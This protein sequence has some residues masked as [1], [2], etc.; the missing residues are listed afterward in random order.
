MSLYIYAQMQMNGLSSL[1]NEMYQ[2]WGIRD[3][4]DGEEES[5]LAAT[6]FASQPAEAR[7]VNFILDK[8]QVINPPNNG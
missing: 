6:I 4:R 2:T 1:S 8:Q 7:A 3:R 5:P